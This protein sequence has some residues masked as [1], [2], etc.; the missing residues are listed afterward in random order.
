M[1]SQYFEYLS[2]LIYSAFYPQA[3][4]ILWAKQT[5]KPSF[6]AS[7]Y[8]GTKVLPHNHTLVY[9]NNPNVSDIIKSG[10]P[11][12]PPGEQS[13]R[14]LNYDY[15]LTQ[16]STTASLQNYLDDLQFTDLHPTTIAKYSHCLYYYSN[17][18]QDNPISHDSAIRFLNHL[19]QLGYQWSTIRVYY[20]SLKPFLFSQGISF[21]FKFKKRRRLPVYHSP[22]QVQ[23]ILDVVS[24]RHDK[25]SNKLKDRDILIILILSYTGIRRSEIL[26]LRL[27]DINFY[28]SML[29]VHGKG[30]NER[31]IPIAKPLFSPLRKY[32]S[33]LKPGDFLFP[34]KPKRLWSIVSRYSALSGIENFH[35][36]SFRHYFATQLVEKGVSLKVVQE[37]LGHEDIGSTAIY[38]NVVPK[39]LS[40]AVSQLPRLNSKRRS[41]VT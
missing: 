14:G 41:N 33:S 34:I 7:L 37:L 29:R 22:D 4:L 30:D 2:M 24:Q 16:A 18:L 23:A 38:L 8:D 12:P 20:H 1:F 26:S 15:P 9:A 6:I 36:H 28:N 31:T 25:W 27:R 35:P 17:W 32:T 21:N 11:I 19:R 3:V 13:S 5:C 10:N 39:H 40:N